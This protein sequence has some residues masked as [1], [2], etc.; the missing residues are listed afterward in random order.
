[1]NYNNIFYIYS[2]IMEDGIERMM[3][4]ETYN[5]HFLKENKMEKNNVKEPIIVN[6]VK[7]SIVVKEASLTNPQ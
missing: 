4:P 3:S 6:D 7:E 2:L 5:I 1:M